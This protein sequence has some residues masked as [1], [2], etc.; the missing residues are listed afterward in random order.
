[1][2]KKKMTK[3]RLT[4]IALFFTLTPI[5]LWVT[6]TTDWESNFWGYVFFIVCALSG[7]FLLAL[8]KNTDK[9]RSILLKLTIFT[10]VVYGLMFLILI[11]PTSIVAELF[12]TAVAAEFFLWIDTLSW[13]WYIALTSYFIGIGLITSL[14]TLYA[15][16]WYDLR[17]NKKLPK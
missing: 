10:V 5:P 15:L 12:P 6:F 4:L 9:A 1:M 13:F 3:L 8:G 14:V 11:G 16:R 17:H 2:R 7:T